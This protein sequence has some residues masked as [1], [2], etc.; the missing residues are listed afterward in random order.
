MNIHR[1]YALFLPRFR[2]SRAQLFRSLLWPTS[3]T[4]ILDVGGYHTF[5]EQWECPGKVICAN[6]DVPAAGAPPGGRFG[7][8]RADGRRLPF[9]D[10]SFDIAFSNSVIEHVGAWADQQAFAGE[11]RR[12]ARRVFVQTPNRW[13]FVEPHLLTPFIHYLPRR[14]QRRLLRYGTVWGWVTRPCHGQVEAFL[15][16]TRLVTLTELKRLFP[17]CRIVRERFL[18]VFTKSFIAVR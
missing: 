11:L 1:L 17:D 12:V 16:S 14:A 3:A 8:V 7:Y 15:N 18:G 4:R 10:G 6:L 2:R 5:W 13:F 9:A